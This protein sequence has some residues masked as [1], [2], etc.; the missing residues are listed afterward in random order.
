[1]NQAETEE[2]VRAEVARQLDLSGHS[3]KAFH[4][5]NLALLA[6]SRVYEQVLVSLLQV[7]GPVLPSAGLDQQLE[8]DL[9]RL[10]EAMALDGQAAFDAEMSA[11]C[12]RLIEAAKG[13]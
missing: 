12:Q 10:F 4:E 3:A 9:R 5:T 1:M 7:L 2:L 13:K 6:R 11:L 8:A